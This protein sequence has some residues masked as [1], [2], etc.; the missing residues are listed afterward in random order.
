MRVRWDGLGLFQGW[1]RV[2]MVIHMNHNIERG[3]A[4]I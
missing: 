3:G 1:L 4:G 2:Q